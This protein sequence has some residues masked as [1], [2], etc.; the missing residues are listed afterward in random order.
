M[1]DG[2][3]D[4]VSTL[5]HLNL[6]G[7][8]IGDLDYF[9]DAIEAGKRMLWQGRGFQLGPAPDNERYVEVQLFGSEVYYFPKGINVMG[10]NQLN[11]GLINALKAGH[12]ALLDYID[13][14][15]A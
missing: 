6:S 4:F 12:E 3:K 15:K 9:H 10:C 11:P 7:T 13:A 14:T 8:L 1:P 2:I 5:P